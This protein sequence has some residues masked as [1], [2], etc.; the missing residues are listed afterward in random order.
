MKKFLSFLLLVFMAF[1]TSGCGSFSGEKAL[2]VLEDSITALSD[3]SRLT[4]VYSYTILDET[5]LTTLKVIRDGENS[6]MYSETSDGETLIKSWTFKDDGDF[7]NFMQ[8]GESKTKII[9]DELDFYEALELGEEFYLFDFVESLREEDEST[10]SISGSKKLFGNTIIKIDFENEMTSGNYEFTIEKDLLKKMTATS[11]SP[12]GEISF[13]V[14][15][16]TSASITKPNTS[17][18]LMF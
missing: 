10:Y 11:S 2:D 7:Y 6:I 16:S 12:M 15:I 13:S 8:N 4:I 3:E 17:E 1:S 14:S 5:A 9:M 18:F